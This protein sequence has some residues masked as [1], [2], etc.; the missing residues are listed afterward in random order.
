MA[1]VG[2]GGVQGMIELCPRLFPAL[3]ENI[4][5]HR[6]NQT[7]QK[8]QTGQG[9]NSQKNFEKTNNNTFRPM[10]G[11]GDIGLNGLFWL[12]CFVVFSRSCSSL[13]LDLF[14]SFVFCCFPYG[15]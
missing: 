3:L 4:K 14:G 10:F 5:N 12:F 1:A 6:E 8:N 2:R 13:F 15:F 9:K 7:K 11:L